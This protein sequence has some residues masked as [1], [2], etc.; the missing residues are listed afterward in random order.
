MYEANKLENIKRLPNNIETDVK[1]MH[2]FLEGTLGF[3]VQSIVDIDYFAENNKR[4][5]KKTPEEVKV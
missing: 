4:A 2:T 1:A 3:E 5:T